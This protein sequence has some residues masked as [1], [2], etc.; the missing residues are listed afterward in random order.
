MTADDGN[1]DTLIFKSIEMFRIIIL[2]AM[3]HK[4]VYILRREKKTRVYRPG[5]MVVMGGLEPPTPAL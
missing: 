2:K 5:R 4:G 1:G 3:V